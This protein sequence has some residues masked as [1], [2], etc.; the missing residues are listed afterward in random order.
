MDSNWAAEHLQTIRTLMERSAIYRRA[1]APVMLSSGIIGI[2]AAAIP[3]FVII[4][5]NRSFAL[6]WMSVGVIAMAAALLLVRRQALRDNESFW[7][8]PTKRV[9]E[10]LMPPFIA[11]GCIGAFLAIFDYRIFPS[12]WLAAGG[13]TILY[14][15]ALNAAGFFTPRGLGLFGRILVFLGC[16]LL[17]SWYMAPGDA[18]VSAHFVM[19]FVFGVLHL[20]YGIYLYFTE[21]KNRA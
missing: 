3:Y 12:G 8:P 21:R 2:I 19:G 4:R 6:Y 13:W 15:C 14:G 17:F 7:S 10:A 20:T 16:G 18:N 9:T 11:G 1:L 5:T